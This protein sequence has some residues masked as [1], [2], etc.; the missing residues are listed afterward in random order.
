MFMLNGQREKGGFL[1]NNKQ[2]INDL[3]KV[4]CYF[5]TLKVI[6]EVVDRFDLWNN[7]DP[8]HLLSFLL[9]NCIANSQ[10]NIKLINKSIWENG[11]YSFF[12]VGY[13]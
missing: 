8:F 9:S 12:I 4:G 3:I 11:W 13:L 7:S 10:F 5:V 6:K 1:A 2:L